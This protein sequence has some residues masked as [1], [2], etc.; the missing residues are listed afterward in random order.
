[1]TVGHEKL[2]IIRFTIPRARERE[3][4]YY[5]YIYTL[6]EKTI[7]NASFLSSS[8]S[9]F[10]KQQFS[11]FVLIRMS[12]E[13]AK[14]WN[15]KNIKET[16]AQYTS[17]GENNCWLLSRPVITLLDAFLLITGSFHSPRFGFLIND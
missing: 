8:A 9:N 12:F 6:K 11:N 1:M 2:Y 14:K 7:N 17:L 15:Q 4:P 10:Y 13:L 16:K 3:L 5:I